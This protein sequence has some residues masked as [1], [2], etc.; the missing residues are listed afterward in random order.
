MIYNKY[1][2]NNLGEKVASVFGTLKKAVS[3]KNII[4]I[5]LSFVMASQTFI[6]DFSPFSFVLFGIAS[7]FNVPLLLVLL[8]SIAGIAITGFTTITL[9]KL[10]SFFVVFTFITALINVEGVSKRLSVFIKLIIS[11]AA[12][13]LL[14]AFVQGVLLTNLFAILGNILLI[15][16]FYYIYIIGIYVLLNIQ[17][18][19]IYS[20]EESVAMILVI[21]LS[22]AIFKDVNILNFSIFNV[23]I[24]ILVLIY[25]WKNGMLAG[26]LAGLVIGLALTGIADVSMTYIVTL[27]FSGLIAGFFSKTGKIGVVIGFIIGNLYISYYANGFSML[28]IHISELLIASIS[29]LFM[30]KALE[31]KLDKLFNKNKTLAKPYENLLDI[32]SNIKARLGAVCE[33]FESLS[34]ITIL[35]TPEESKETREVI[36]KYIVDYIENTCIDCENRRRCIDSKNL[37]ITVD[38]IANKLENNEL[39]NKS[40]LKLDCDK[41][42]EEKIIYDIYEIYNSMKLMRILKQKEKENSIKLS[43]QY[44]EVSNILSNI[45]KNIKNEAVIV[46]KNQEKLREELKFY[47]FIVYEDEYIME[48]GVIEYT[49]ITDILNDIDKQKEKIINIATDILEQK[50][51]IKLILNISKSEKSKIRIVSTPNYEVYTSIKSD[52]KAG[53]EISGDSYLSMELKDLKHMNILSDG[54]GSGKIASKGSKTVINMLEK[55]LEGGFSEE[56][57]IDIINSVLKLKGDDSMFSTLDTMIIDLKNAEAQFIKLGAAPTYIIEDGKIITIKNLSIPIGLINDTDYAP[58]CKKLKE[59]SVIIQLS[60][61]VIPDEMNKEQ[62]YFTKHLQNIDV[63]KTPKNIAEELNKFVLKENKNELKDDVTIIV[64]KIRKSLEK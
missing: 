19:Y 28:T 13:E 37:D 43:K 33:V 50:M 56:K 40:M 11:Q 64:T 49:F 53:S 10:I 12:V 51:N 9:I 14:F 27:A 60:D 23:F 38:Y 52:T 15:S 6:G 63:L 7:V 39:I 18:G 31:L 45:A 30:P 57:S 8:S 47:G 4:F 29:L 42:Q 41:S 61:G 32:S 5:I 20:K 36:K 62:N 48:N 55:L 26:G 22:L 3:F 44:K 24:L 54:A 21:A 16:I 34:Q 46:E 2:D 25:G 35:S 58:I 59:N 1:L 17:K